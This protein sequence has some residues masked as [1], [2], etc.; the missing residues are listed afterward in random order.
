M[1]L[2]PT[3]CQPSWVFSCQ[4]ILKLA[5]KQV[6]ELEFPLGNAGNI[7]WRVTLSTGIPWVNTWPGRD[8][9]TKGYPHPASPHSP[10]PWGGG[11]YLIENHGLQEPQPRC[12][13]RMCQHSW[14][15][16]EDPEVAL[17]CRVWATYTWNRD[18]T[19]CCVCSDP[20]DEIHWPSPRRHCTWL[21]STQASSSSPHQYVALTSHEAQVC[22]LPSF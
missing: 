18:R 20:V 3:I 4:T 8:S 17:I 6:V 15:L 2:S 9:T 12:C 19:M 7:G 16:V 21:R 22:G 10:P 1:G 13:V 5:P 14:E 11:W